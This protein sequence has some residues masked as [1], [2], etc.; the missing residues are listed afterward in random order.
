M[1]L[2]KPVRR[3]GCGVLLVLWFLFLLTPCAVF[4]LAVQRE[5]VIKWSEV[6][7]DELRIWTIQDRDA[8]GIGIAN[9]R[10]VN[11]TGSGSQPVE[12]SAENPL[13]CTITD[14]RFILWQGQANPAHSCSCFQKQQ[15]RWAEVVVGQDACTLAGE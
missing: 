7:Q 10:R 4:V 2:P 8:R 5:I 9:S 6:P 14:I 3:F 15:S 1:K 12:Y 13:I 11:T